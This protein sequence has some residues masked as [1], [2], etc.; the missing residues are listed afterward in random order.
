MKNRN[1]KS[2]LRTVLFTSLG[3]V[4]C[5]GL[6]ACM[7][8]TPGIVDSEEISSS[9]PVSEVTA[10]EKTKSFAGRVAGLYSS[11]SDDTKVC[12]TL[13]NVYGNLYGEKTYYQLDEGEYCKYA[14]EAVEII[15]VNPAD[16]EDETKTECEVG[17]VCYSNMYN[18]GLYSGAPVKAKISLTGSGLVI[19]YEDGNYAKE[20]YI[21]SADAENPFVYNEEAFG[22]GN[23]VTPDESTEGLWRQKGVEDPVYLEIRKS[24][25]DQ[26]DAIQIYRKE[27]GREAGFGRGFLK[28]EADGNMKVFYNTIQS[29][30]EPYEWTFQTTSAGDEMTVK[31]VSGSLLLSDDDNTVFEKIDGTEVPV[32]AMYEPDDKE[33]YSENITYKTAG[34]KERSVIPQFFACDDVENNGG[35]FVRL[36]KLIFYRYYDNKLL[37]ESIGFM[38]S[39]MESWGLQDCSY[40]CYYDPETRET[41][42]AFK[43]HGSGPLYYLN[44]WF[45]SSVHDPESDST[46]SLFRCQP[47]GSGQ[48]SLAEDGKYNYVLASSEDGQYLAYMSAASSMVVS[49]R[50]FMDNNYYSIEKNEYLETANYLDHDLFMTVYTGEGNLDF[51][52]L[53]EDERGLVK[54]GSFPSD[55][56]YQVGYPYIYQIYRSEENGDIYAGLTWI[57][58]SG[59]VEGFTV[60]QMDGKEDGKIDVLFDEYPKGCENGG[61]PYFYFNYADEVLIRTEETGAVYL[62]D[63]KSGDLVYSDSAYSAV[64][65]ANNYISEN[66]NNVKADEEFTE[67][68][69]A[70][71]VGGN[72]FLVRANLKRDTKLAYSVHPQY[73]LQ[74]F[75]FSVI[76]MDTV[77]G[78]GTKYEEILLTPEL[79]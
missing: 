5:A 74:S 9:E 54:I 19:N 13:C 41:G 65:L 73:D 47:D 57:D 17:I 30:A 75:A 72:A 71:M 10:A 64:I 2:V 52:M 50:G 51:Y 12:L 66:P 79:R 28:A 39:F 53:Y 68:E 45:V 49:G 37:E 31:T 38:G 56:W 78:D 63:G 16:L 76:P 6:S 7:Q 14:Y 11:E 25:Y 35:Y 20:E 60:L 70:E 27:R 4:L 23:Y 1:S 62:S 22:G 18:A 33:A 24:A 44:G 26:T 77:S 48:I 36:G 34:G 15:P 29:S 61:L 46:N 3:L 55:K 42:V 8:A 40:V 59:V 32:V 69:K 67:L 21:V 58:T 43:D